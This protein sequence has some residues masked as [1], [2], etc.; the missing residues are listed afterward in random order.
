M[1]KRIDTSD[2]TFQGI[3]MVSDIE[4]PG[5]M[6]PTAYNYNAAATIDDGTCVYEGPGCMDIHAGN[7]NPGATIEDGTCEGFGPFWLIKRD[8]TPG[9]NN[10]SAAIAHYGTNDVFDY[11]SSVYPPMNFSWSDGST[12]YETTGLSLG[13]LSVIITATSDEF[14][15]ESTT[16]TPWLTGQ[17]DSFSTFIFTNFVY[18]CT[19]STACNYDYSYNTDDG[20]CCYVCGCTDP[21]AIN[22]DATA[23]YDDGSCTY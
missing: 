1:G 21:I 19:N 4:I 20:S 12:S 14:V 6:D 15:T 3:S 10:G 2:F 23:C 7:Y 16:I 5:C 22:Y 17:T 8:A 18:G 9:F 13:P 11:V